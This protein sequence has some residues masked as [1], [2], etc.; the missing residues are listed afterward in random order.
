MQSKLKDVNSFTK[1]ISIDVPWTDLEENFIKTFKDFKKGY[2]IP[3]FRKGR[4]PDNIVKRNFG[5][6]IEADFT[7]K[8][9]NKYY[10]LALQELRL[11]PINKA[12]INN[13]EFKEGSNL[14]YTAKFEITPDFKLFDY[15]KKLKI[16][17]IRVKQT[18]TDVDEALLNLQKQH[19]TIKP[20]KDGAKIGHFIQ[21]D[22]QELDESDIPII[23]K[24][25]E[26]QYICYGEGVFS[27]EGALS[28]EGVK[29][30]DSVKVNIDYGEG[31]KVRY[32]ISI[33]KVD[34]QI[35]PEVNDDFAK[36]ADPKVKSLKELKDK[37]KDS[38]QDS[39]DKEY[40]NQIDQN[41]SRYIVD[42]TKVEIP[43]SMR[44]NYI[45]NVMEDLKQK[46]KNDKPLNRDE[47]TKMYKD[48]ADWNIAWYLIRD[49]LIREN[50]IKVN[51]K[52]INSKIDLAAKNSSLPID[53]VKEFYKTQENRRKIEDDVINEKLFNHL[54]EFATIKEKSKTTDQLRKEKQ[55]N[56]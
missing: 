14:K 25:Y 55:K 28:L 11:I 19:A 26:K 18:N 46:N 54:K 3:G 8:S 2:S 40:S 32:E 52:D 49:K 7:E 24:K 13:L 45:D 36:L 51:D 20:V 6:A 35:L 16:D 47:I 1:E 29:K 33:N 41:I 21:G 27:G 17:A 50:N 15:K 23:G 9:I 38:I 37:L 34:E 48:I 43:N 42:K 5:P 44:E 12:E 39:L 56:G 4:V 22:F 30:D 10:Q 53:Q 31:K